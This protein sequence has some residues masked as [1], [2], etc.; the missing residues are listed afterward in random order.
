M[1]SHEEKWTGFNGNVIRPG[2]F[3]TRQA[4]YVTIPNPRLLAM[5]PRVA[6]RGISAAHSL[7]G[8]CFATIYPVMR[9]PATTFAKI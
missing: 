5:I 7:R 4:T 9:R 1:G 3:E 2:T 6:N 8:T